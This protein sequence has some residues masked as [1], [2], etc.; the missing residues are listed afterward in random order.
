MVAAGARGHGAYAAG[1]CGTKQSTC[2]P[3]TLQLWPEPPLSE[4]STASRLGSLAEAR[5]R[6]QP[7]G[8]V[9]RVDPGQMLQGPAQQT[10]APVTGCPLHV[11]CDGPVVSCTL[12]QS[13]KN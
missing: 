8:R 4:P 3:S 5:R 12:L 10:D 6:A 7:L 9:V 2:P 1:K 11:V 13:M